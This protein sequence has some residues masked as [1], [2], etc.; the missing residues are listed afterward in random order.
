[1]MELLETTLRDGSYAIDFTFTPQDTA[2]LALA[3]EKAGLRLIEVGHGLGLNASNCGK[4]RMPAPDV[5]YISAT[6][7]VLSQA[8]FGVFCI[9]GIARVEDIDEAAAAG[10]DV[11]RIGTNITELE[12]AA[13]YY[14]RAKRHGLFVSAN[15]MKSYTVPAEEFGRYTR[16]AQEFGADIAVLVDSAGGFFPHDV[17]AYYA[18]SRAAC[19]V[20]LGYHGHNNLGFANANTLRAIELGAKIVDCS[21][22]GMGRSAGN[23]VTEMM[24]MV[25]K[26]LGYPL[27]I[28]EYAVMDLAEKY[29]T[30]LLHNVKDT[31]I[32]ITGGYAQFHSSFLDVVM[33]YADHYRV[34][35]REL[36]VRLTEKDKVHAPERLVESLAADLARERQHPG[37]YSLPADV[38]ERFQSAGREQRTRGQIEALAGEMATLS[39]KKGKPSVFNIVLSYKQQNFL[40][41][42]I[43]ESPQFVIG[44]LELSDYD[45]FAPMLDTVRT[46]FD[47]ILLDSAPKLPAHTGLLRRLREALPGA[48]LLPYNDLDCWARSVTA[49]LVSLADAPAD[50]AVLV[51][52]AGPLA[53]HIAL[54]LAEC[55]FTLVEKP[56]SGLFA[57][58][59]CERATSLTDWP[60]TPPRV[61]VDAGIGAIAPTLVAD[62]LE[63]GVRLLRPDMRAVIAAEAHLQLM[64]RRNVADLERREIAG[65]PVVSGGLIGR[66]GD[67]VVDSVSHPTQV[68]GVACGDGTVRYDLDRQEL[69]TSVYMLNEFNRLVDTI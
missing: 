50:E 36:I 23:A 48:G 51:R 40:S 12:A 10:I 49:T 62:W 65:Q 54:L 64:H 33:R 52:G 21:L 56:Q 55:G 27:Q 43:N 67:W 5:D 18:S 25:L 16:Q 1:M 8:R 69:A 17:E 46:G 45:F 58:V 2:E 60:H 44:S 34:D 13:P 68:V 61:A 11:L 35:P 22:K 9:P 37:S 59:S 47:H 30:P 66:R 15:L 31:P 19:N 3:L 41:A 28:D 42:Y 29:I 32:S 20:A 63:A 53:R 57:V 4:G 39:R 14:E 24:V 7:E 26:R 6:R 38:L